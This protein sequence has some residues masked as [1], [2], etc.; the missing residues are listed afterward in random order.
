VRTAFG[1]F[2]GMQVEWFHLLA[3][4]SA[5]AAN[6]SVFMIYLA[7][8]F[9][10]TAQGMQ[11]ALLLAF[12]ISIPRLANYVGVR[13]GARFSVLL[14]VAK[15]IPSALIITLGIARFGQHFELIQP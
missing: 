6:A 8:F 5:G 15:L 12:L 3:C 14:T 13:T 10:W 7:G 9:P 2:A 11:R 1:R 4:V